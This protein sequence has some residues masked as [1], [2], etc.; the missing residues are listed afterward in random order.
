MKYHS[1]N[2][3]I[4]YLRPS[5]SRTKGTARHEKAAQNVESNERQRRP[6]GHS[7]ATN[8]S[9]PS[10]STRLRAA[11]PERAGRDVRVYVYVSMWCV[12]VSVCGAWVAL[13]SFHI[14]CGC[15]WDSDCRCCCCC[16]CPAPEQLRIIFVLASFPW[17]SPPLYS[18]AGDSGF[19]SAWQSCGCCPVPSL[20]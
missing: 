19:G 9:R 8:F 2:I 15:R 10:P 14:G 16:A 7:T 17:N 11:C 1:C 6:N 18:D 5:L 3:E 4:L 13:G 20:D 12:Y